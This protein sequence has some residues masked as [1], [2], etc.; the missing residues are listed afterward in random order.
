MRKFVRPA[1]ALSLLVVPLSVGLAGVAQLA[2]FQAEQILVE[3]QPP[4][5]LEVLGLDRFTLLV[6]IETA[7][8]LDL[9]PPMLLLRNAEIV[10]GTE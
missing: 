1:L 6:N 2:G 8:A 5:D 4:G 10:D 9:Y 3:G 7:R